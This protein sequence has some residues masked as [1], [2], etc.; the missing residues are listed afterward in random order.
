MQADAERVLAMQKKK[1]AEQVPSISNL[2][3]EYMTV[4]LFMSSSESTKM[5]CTVQ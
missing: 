5:L 2:V 1:H 4:N 3:N